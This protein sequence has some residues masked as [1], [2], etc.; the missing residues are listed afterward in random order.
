MN[1]GGGVNSTAMY[2][3]VKEK[4][5]QLDEVIFADTGSELPRTYIIV[6]QFKKIIEADG[7][8]FTIVKSHLDKSL[9][10]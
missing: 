7:I 2:F 6:A 9:Y 10:D 3:L 5:L 1:F 8:P 4:K